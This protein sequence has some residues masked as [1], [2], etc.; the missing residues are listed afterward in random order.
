L[1]TTILWF[2]YYGT[3]GGKRIAAVQRDAAELMQMMVVS[4]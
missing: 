1:V 4:G 3:G 2:T